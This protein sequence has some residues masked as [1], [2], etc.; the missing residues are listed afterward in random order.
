MQFDSLQNIIATLHKLRDAYHNQ[1][2]A[3]TLAELDDVLIRLKRLGEVGRRDIPL[4]TI[5]VQCVSIVDHVV[6]AVTNITD[7]M[8]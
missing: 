3:G 4:G 7:L 8:K 1:L 6:R 2:D 5:A